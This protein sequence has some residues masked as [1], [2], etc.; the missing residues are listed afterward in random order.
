MVNFSFKQL[1][2]TSSFCFHKNFN[3][4]VFANKK[5]INKRRDNMSNKTFGFSQNFD[6][7]PEK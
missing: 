1:L 5:V 6:V 4:L 7:C 3:I 2:K